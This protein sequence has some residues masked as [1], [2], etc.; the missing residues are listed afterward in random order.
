MIKIVLQGAMELLARVY[1]MTNDWPNAMEAADMVLEKD[2]KA[3]KVYICAKMTIYLFIFILLFL[4]FRQSKSKLKL[5]STFASLNM[6][7][8]IFIGEW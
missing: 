5:Y 3:A 8:C 4:P 1:L 7:W 2:K 6:Q